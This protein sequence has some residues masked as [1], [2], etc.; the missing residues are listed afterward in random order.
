VR[1]QANRLPVP[2]RDR[3][4]ALAAVAVLLILAGALASGLLVYRSGERTDVLVARADIDPGHRMTA[5]DFTTARVAADGS[6]VVDAAARQN[7]VGS[8]ATTRIPAGTLVNR[9]MFLKGSIVPENGAVVGLVLAPNQRPAE[10][11]QPG[12]VVRVYLVPR[13]DA[14]GVAADGA[15]L[16]RAVLVVSVGKSRAGSSQGVPVSVLVAPGT[17]PALIAAAA[18]GQVAV[19][20]LAADTKPDVA[21]R[22]G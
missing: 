1:V 2:V 17:A 9:S 6:A 8:V 15:P 16:A 5:A 4:P 19:A 7:F 21:F 12:E 13:A 10:D 18:S 20:R 11:L 3:R 22:T 14:G